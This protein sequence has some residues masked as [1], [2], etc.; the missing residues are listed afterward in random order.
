MSTIPAADSRRF[1][2]VLSSARIGGNAEQLAREASLALPADVEQRWLRL[3]EMPL[4][5]FVDIRHDAGVYASPEGHEATLADATLWCTDLVMV[6]PVYWYS[7]PANAKLYLDH[8]SGWMRVPGM[9]FKARMAGKRMWGVT[10][11]SGDDAASAEPV[12]GTLRL[13]ANYLRM[14]W[15]G[16]L[17][18]HGSRPGDVANDALALAEARR[19]FTPP[20]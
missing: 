4:E 15:K 1:L 6:V 11:I 20:A 7:V 12:V 2:F 10:V 16:V 19:F 18:G 13:T 3:S 17:L 14:E 8:W 9:E 5:P